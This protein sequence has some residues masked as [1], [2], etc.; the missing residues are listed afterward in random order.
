MTITM[1]I[2]ITIVPRCYISTTKTTPEPQGSGSSL[3]T[4]GLTFRDPSWIFP[5]F[6]ASYRGFHGHG[7]T[8]KWLIYNG[9]P[10]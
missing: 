6:V 3:A 10:H 7:G 8:P 5:I 1:A 9:K 4:L 2:A